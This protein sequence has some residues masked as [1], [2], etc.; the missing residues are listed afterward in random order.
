MIADQ[1][2]APSERRAGHGPELRQSELR[3]SEF[4]QSE[5]RH[6]R[7]GNQGRFRL[8]AAV[9]AGIRS[10]GTSDAAGRAGCLQAVSRG[11]PLRLRRRGC[12]EHHRGYGLAPAQAPA[13]LQPGVP[14]ALRERVF[15]RFWRADRRST[16]A[17]LGL[18][19]VRRVMEL[20]GGQVVVTDAP[21]GGAHFT[22]RFTADAKVDSRGS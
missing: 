3:Q 17:G 13:I 20:H 2:V 11:N 21:G 4:R 18:A 19:I 5:F 7:A 10:A 16:G 12:L 14:E 8:G 9:P 15:E 6:R 1:L 22:L